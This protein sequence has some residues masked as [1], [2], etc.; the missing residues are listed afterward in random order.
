MREKKERENATCDGANV[1]QQARPS[2]VDLSVVRNLPRKP[3]ATGAK[4]T[5]QFIMDR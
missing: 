4:K 5:G 3:L 1:G 2:D